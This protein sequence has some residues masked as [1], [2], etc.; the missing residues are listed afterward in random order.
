MIFYKVFIKIVG[1]ENKWGVYYMD[2]RK[3]CLT[4]LKNNPM[5]KTRRYGL[6]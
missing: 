4:Y 1:Q 5:I 6:L 3:E 2:G